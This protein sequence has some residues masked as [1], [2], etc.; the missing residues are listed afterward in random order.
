[1]ALEYAR[2]DSIRL[3]EEAK[4]TFKYHI[5]VGSFI[6]PEYARNFADEFRNKGYNVKILQM[7]GGRFELVSAEAFDRLR[8]AIDK[9]SP[10]TK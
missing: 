10:T 2:Q 8:P 7:P 3:A 6:T 1:M 9:L 5:I 4:M